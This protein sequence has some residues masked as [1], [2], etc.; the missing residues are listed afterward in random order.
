MVAEL[1]KANLDI[2]DNEKAN[3]DIM[4][5]QKRG[6]PLTKA[7][8]QHIANLHRQAENRRKRKHTQDQKAARDAEIKAINDEYL[9]K[10][11]KLQDEH[12]SKLSKVW[13]KWREERSAA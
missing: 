12:R 3:L 6:V 11:Q 8:Q 5:K 7:E 2:M 10:I 4:D 1:E 9:P 13:N